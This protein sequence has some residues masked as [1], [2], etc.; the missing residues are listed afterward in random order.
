MSWLLWD[1][2]FY[3]NKLFQSNFLIALAGERTTLLEISGG[4]R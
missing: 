1:I 4:E 3:G 2:A